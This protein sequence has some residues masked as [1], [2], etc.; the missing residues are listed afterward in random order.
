MQALAAV[1]GL[2]LRDGW[3]GLRVDIGIS[4][5]FGGRT[6]RRMVGEISRSGEWRRDGL[7]AVEEQLNKVE[8]LVAVIADGEKQRVADRLHYPAEAASPAT[9]R[10]WAES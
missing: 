4:P 10:A 9:R 5:V 7:W 6:G 3:V 2:Q 1:T 8:E